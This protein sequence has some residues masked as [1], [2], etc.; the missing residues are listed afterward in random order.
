MV[1]DKELFTAVPA[2]SN[3]PAQ[4]TAS[5]PLAQQTSVSAPAQTLQIE[6]VEVAERVL[7][8]P[9]KTVG[10]P[11]TRGS[12]KRSCR[13]KRYRQPRS[14]FKAQNGRICTAPCRK[15]VSS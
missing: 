13:C 11:S 8:R 3:P 7:S 1:T 5:L 4:E 14:R 9:G 2:H 12:L 10:S 15:A 6:T